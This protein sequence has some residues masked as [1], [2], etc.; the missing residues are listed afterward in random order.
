MEPE[1]RHLIEV[2]KR[3]IEAAGRKNGDVERALRMS[4]G[5]LSRLF[6]GNIALRF[7]HIVKIAG[8]LGLSPAE[9]FQALYPVPK[10]PP[11]ASMV[12]LQE[13][14]RHLKPSPLPASGW[15]PEERAAF[16]RH[17]ETSLRQ[18]LGR[19]RLSLDA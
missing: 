12:R 8:A 13:A 9:I 6:A 15:T 1:T 10:D 16:E 11:T 18:A 5:Y 19:L 2:L 7:E 4:P 17:L 3:A 14:L